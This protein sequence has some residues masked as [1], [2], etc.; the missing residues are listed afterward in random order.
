MR[1]TIPITATPRRTF[2]PNFA[3]YPV[4]VGLGQAGSGELSGHQPLGARQYRRLIS[5]HTTL[6][7]YGDTLS[8]TKGK[9]A[10]QIRR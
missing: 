5:D 9:H 1:L 4:F 10:L 2:F 8:W 7:Q 3:G 6:L